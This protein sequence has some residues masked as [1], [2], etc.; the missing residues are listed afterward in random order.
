M[1]HN[2]QTEYFLHTSRFFGDFTPIVPY[3]AVFFSHQGISI[4]QISLLFFVWALT[5]MVLE[6]PT[7]ILADKINRKTIL[8]LSRLAKVSCFAAWLISPTFVGFL[9]GFV[10]WGIA[11]A[12]DSGAFQAFVYEHLEETGHHNLFEKFYG[13]ATAW[14]FVGLLCSALLASIAIGKGFTF[15]VVITI[16]NVLISLITLLFIPSKNRLPIHTDTEQSLPSLAKSLGLIATGPL[17]LTCIIVGITAGGIKGS[18]EEYYSLLLESKAIP[19]TL[20]G[21]AIVGFEAMKS[22][23]S[24]L[25]GRFQNSE[26]KQLGLLGIMGIALCAAA[27]LPSIYTVA[28]LAILTLLD[29]ILWIMNDS[30]IQHLATTN[31]RATLASFKNFG[32]EAIALVAFLA[33]SILT[34]RLTLETMYLIGGVCMLIVSIALAS[35]LLQN[36]RINTSNNP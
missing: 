33:S 20:I 12:L 15:L 23:G 34:R 2:K 24:F 25:A 16:I 27:L 8:I 11:T 17:L 4:S 19:L 10:L 5:I 35:N 6:I 13:N 31:N 9:I 21:F 30:S 26:K 7:G 18:L 32:V 28:A 36:R 22:L 1:H 29:A 3:A 14:S